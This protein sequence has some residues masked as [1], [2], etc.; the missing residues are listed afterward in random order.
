MASNVADVMMGLLRYS[1]I[2]SMV[3]WSGRSSVIAFHR[4]ANGIY[5]KKNSAEMG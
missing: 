3:E 1:V 5:R 2:F 4:L